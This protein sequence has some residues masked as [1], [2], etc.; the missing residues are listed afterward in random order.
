MWSS[1]LPRQRYLIYAV[2]ATVVLVGAGWLLT[3]EQ[4]ATYQETTRKATAAGL[5]PVSFH[6][7][8]PTSKFKVLGAG[9][10]SEPASGP[11]YVTLD[12]RA[13]SGTLDRRFQVGPFQPGRFAAKPRAELPILAIP[14]MKRAERTYGGYQLRIEGGGAVAFAPAYQFFFDASER[15]GGPKG[16]KVY[17]RVMV[18]ARPPLDQG[19]TI[20]MLA[21]GH[22]GMD[23]ATDLVTDET[24]KGMLKSFRFGSS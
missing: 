12:Q 18:V 19:V 24:F 22:T 11:A 20:T 8:Y 2:A 4:Q 6:F 17:G 14:I 5:P 1:L 7:D 23:Q 3:R 15:V 13:G 9:R 16:Q 21:T 10:A